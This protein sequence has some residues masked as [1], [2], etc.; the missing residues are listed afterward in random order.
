MA[1]KCSN[2]H[3]QKKIKTSPLTALK[4]YYMC[5]I[6]RC[7]TNGSPAVT[8]SKDSGVPAMHA[9]TCGCFQDLLAQAAVCS[10]ACSPPAP[11][12]PSLCAGYLATY[13]HRIVLLKA[14]EEPEDQLIPAPCTSADSTTTGPHPF[15]SLI[16]SR[17]IPHGIKVH[18]HWL[19][20]FI[21]Y[22]KNLRHQSSNFCPRKITVALGSIPSPGGSTYDTFI[23]HLDS[24]TNLS[25]WNK[26]NISNCLVRTSSNRTD[27]HASSP[28]MLSQL[29]LFLQIFSRCSGKALP[30]CLKW[31]SLC[32]LFDLTCSLAAGNETFCNGTEL[33]EDFCLYAKPEPSRPREAL[34]AAVGEVG[35]KPTL[36]GA[37]P[38]LGGRGDG[39]ELQWRCLERRQRQ[40]GG[41]L[42]GQKPGGRT[43]ESAQ[44]G[45]AG[46]GQARRKGRGTQGWGVSPGEKD[47]RARKREAI[48]KGSTCHFKGI[49]ANQS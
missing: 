37:E 49:C 34:G 16:K 45:T 39:L 21:L 28:V 8:T 36:Q 10:A 7:V 23:C 26:V 11:H 1:F 20:S 3:I 13:L 19:W 17:F 40:S 41:I 18:T 46:C 24:I 15:P 27:L 31:K 6:S 47:R 2:F 12:S 9:D 32:S 25:W 42:P 22:V 30:P 38:A 43:E 48:G 14:C 44:P 35:K 5:L 33:V 4:N 29:S